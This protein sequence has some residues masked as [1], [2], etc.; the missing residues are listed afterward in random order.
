MLKREHQTRLLSLS[1]CTCSHSVSFFTRDLATRRRS[2]LPNA[3]ENGTGPARSAAAR[4]ETSTRYLRYMRRSERIGGQRR[5]G[6]PLVIAEDNG[7]G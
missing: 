6:K 1:L 7:P 2:A 5:A 4:S 3:R